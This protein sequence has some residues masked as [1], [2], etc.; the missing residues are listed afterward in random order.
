MALLR[1]FALFLPLIW[2]VPA[3]AAAGGFLVGFAQDTLANDWRQAQAEGLAREFARHPAVEFRVTDG[4]GRTAQQILDI[5]DL[6]A[7]GVDLLITSPKDEL[8]MTPAI[9]AAYRAG[10]PVLLL[11]RRIASDDYTTFITPDDE[12]IARRAARFIAERLNRRGRVLVLQGVPTAT[13]AKVRTEAF[14]DELRHFPEV[15]IVGIEPANYLRS[16]AIRVTERVLARGLDFD[17]VY[18][19][20]DSMAAGARM[21]LAHAGIDPGSLVIVGIDY[22][23]E[24]REAIRRGEQTASFTYPVCAKEGTETALRILRGERVP[25]RITIPSTMVTHDNVEQVEPIF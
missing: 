24:A 14:F 22:I 1:Q 5:E 9:S 12:G 4:Q 3:T 10:T 23:G 25:K 8:A 20:S 7:A 17:A 11:T 21:A 15:E 13:T 6:V 19:Q 2:L 18:A 16:D